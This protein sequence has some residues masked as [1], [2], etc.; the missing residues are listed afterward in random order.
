MNVVIIHPTPL[1]KYEGE[2]SGLILGS[3]YLG[4]IQKS[5]QVVLFFCGWITY[6]IHLSVM[7]QGP[8]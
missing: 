6:P 2:L 4:L 8:A 5:S 3:V 1:A 7:L